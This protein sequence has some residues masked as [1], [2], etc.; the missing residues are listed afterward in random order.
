MAARPDAVDSRLVAGV[1]TA[2][3]LGIVVLG[4]V[5][6]VSAVT[7]ERAGRLHELTTVVPLSVAHAASAATA[8][9]GLLLILLG[10][11]LRRR[12]RRAWRGAGVQGRAI[13]DRIALPVNA[14]SSSS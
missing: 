13:R 6:V 10:H 7:P 9:T 1:P 11:G 3:A 12:K 14:S 4:V 8:V 2:F 5:D